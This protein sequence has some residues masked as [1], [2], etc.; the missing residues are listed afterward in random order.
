MLTVEHP[1]GPGLRE[2]TA[3]LLSAADRSS[4]G[5]GW[6]EQ[7][8]PENPDGFDAVPDC[9]ALVVEANREL[10]RGA[11]ELVTL[12]RPLGKESASGGIVESFLAQ[13]VGAR[14][15]FM[16]H[17]NQLVASPTGKAGA[18]R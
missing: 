7:A 6:L 3:R 5:S 17:E 14:P 11:R 15:V 2:R 10:T 16:V 12:E 18:V 4:G 13:G 9:G 8:L 1:D